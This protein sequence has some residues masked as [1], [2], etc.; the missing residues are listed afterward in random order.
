MDLVILIVL[1]LSAGLFIVV[2]LYTCF[3][4]GAC[5]ICGY[6]HTEGPKELLFVTVPRGHVI[7]RPGRS[8]NWISKPP[9][10]NK[11][12]QVNPTDIK[13]C[14]YQPD[15]AKVISELAEQ[16]YKEEPSTKTNSSTKSRRISIT[17]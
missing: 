8:L 4:F 15:I 10:R 1:G 12:Q 17:V 9:T 14:Q 13:F 16:S 7:L 3:F 5:G 6:N 11:A 2:T